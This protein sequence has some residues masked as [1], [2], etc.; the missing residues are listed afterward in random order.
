MYI[1][2][3]LPKV[4]Y[5]WFANICSCDIN[6]VFRISASTCV[7]SISYLPISYLHHINV[8]SWHHALAMCWSW[9]DIKSEFCSERQLLR[10]CNMHNCWFWSVPVPGEFPR[11]WPSLQI[12]NFSKLQ[13]KFPPNTSKST[14]LW[15]RFGSHVF[16]LK[17]PA[18]PNREL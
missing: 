17:N 18:R 10:M 13:M 15:S 7:W 1:L 8:F 2:W 4:Q 11:P 12:Y 16:S 6:M 14:Q 9:F 5:S 3:Y